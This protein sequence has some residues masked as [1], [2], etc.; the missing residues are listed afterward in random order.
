MIRIYWRA[1]VSRALLL[2]VAMSGDAGTASL[3]KSSLPPEKEEWIQI[4]TAHFT[5]FS[6]APERRALELGRSLERFRA[7]LSAFQ[8][9]LRIDPPQPYFIYISRNHESFNA[10]TLRE[11]GKL[12]EISGLCNPG[13]D[14]NY[15]MMSAAWNEDPRPIIYHEFTHQFIG[16]NL[17]AVPTWFNEGLAEYY[18]T[19]IGDDK[20]ASLG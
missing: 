12:A 14:A 15:I 1:I 18:S 16:N 9:D 5:I 10:Y 20:R 3:T 7:V 2:T 8:T 4:E 19:F 6:N 17:A 13:W 11:N